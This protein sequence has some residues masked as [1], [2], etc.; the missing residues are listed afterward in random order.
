MEGMRFYYSGYPTT[1][2]GMPESYISDVSIM[3]TFARQCEFESRPLDKKV[4]EYPPFPIEPRMRRLDTMRTKKWKERGSTFQDG[5]RQSK[6][7]QKPT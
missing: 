4:R 6:D 1:P 5:M 3:M 2:S 7:V